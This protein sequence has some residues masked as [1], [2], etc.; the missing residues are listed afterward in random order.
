MSNIKSFSLFLFIIFTF[1]IFGIS[2]QII[3]KEEALQYKPPK[4]TDDKQCPKNVQC[5]K[6][7]YCDIK[8]FCQNE[9]CIEQQEGMSYEY[10]QD[11]NTYKTSNTTDLILETCPEEARNME[12]CF[13][14]YCSINDNCYS[15][16]CINNTCVASKDVTI[17][18]CLFSVDKMICN[19]PLQESCAKD[20]ECHSG[21]CNDYKFC[22]DIS[23][24]IYKKEEVLKYKPPNCN[25]DKE[26]PN[27]VKCMKG[28]CNTIF[29]CQND[30]CK[31][32]REG[33]SYEYHLDVNTYKSSN[34]TDLILESCPEE[35]RNIGK[36]FTRYC[37]KDENCYSN[38]CIN[39]TCI[40][41]KDIT[42]NICLYYSDEMTCTKPTQESCTTNEE[43][44]PG[45]CNEYNFCVEVTEPWHFYSLFNLILLFSVFI[46]IIVIIVMIIKR[47]FF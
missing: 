3:T 24:K 25:D 39:N 19:K 45:T 30:D 7:G 29:F 4:C 23:K 42:T 14:R 46:V 44:Y 40:A 1:E 8:I 2:S 35:A 16:K 5:T 15:N 20:E 36:C 21:F 9:F 34:T 43:C 27:N 33:M 22:D 31:E 10:N 11:I 37:E 41:N 32:Q 28:Y 17:N 6:D 47:R 18:V 13:T 12:K 38:K 26:C